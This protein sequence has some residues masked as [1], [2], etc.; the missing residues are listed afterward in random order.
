[1]TLIMK[2][3]IFSVALILYSSFSFAQQNGIPKHYVAIKETTGDL[4]KDGIDEKVVVYNMSDKE[5]EINGIGRELI[6]YKKEKGQ[7]RIWQRSKT[8][9]GNSQDGGMMGDPFEDIEI[10]AGILIISQSGGSSWKW[11]TTDKYR[12]QNNQFQLIGYTSYGG[13]LCEYWQTFDYNISTGKIT[14]EKE[15]ENCDEEGTQTISKKQNENFTYRLKK[16]ITLEKRNKEAI[17]ITSPK[18]K[19]ELYL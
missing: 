6:I 9:V 4:N 2:Q 13:K 19:H 5:D 3:T 14:V 15:F 17:K 12:F 18:Y 11:N 10:K 16:P 1:M 8:A 7:W